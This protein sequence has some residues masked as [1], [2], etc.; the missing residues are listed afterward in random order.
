MSPDPAAIA[1]VF[2]LV[3]VMIV[4]LAL[5]RLNQS[6]PSPIFS[7]LN[8][9]LRCIALAGGGALLATRLGWSERPFA[10]LA[11]VFLLG[12]F[13][14]ETIYH[15]LAIHAMSVSPLPLF[16]RYTVNPGGDEWPVS[17]S[18]LRLRDH[19]RA[20]GF[21]FVQGLRAEV[22]TDVHLRTSFYQTS[23]ATIRLQVVFLP[24]PSGGISVCLHLSSQTADGS[25]IVTDNH[26]LPFAGFYPEAWWVERSPWTRSLGA[27]L[28]RHRQR[29]NKMGVTLVPWT[30]EPIEDVN[31]QQSRLE[32]LN[33]ELGFLLPTAEHEEHGRISSPGR[34]RIWKELF[35]LNYFG[36][37]ARYH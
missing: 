1:P 31:A 11:A 27:L 12:W 17:R 10:V 15:W 7:L 26:Y 3:P 20:A 13:L 8:R 34:Y 16:P 36:R 29:V 37:A 28:K 21:K 2:V 14:L 35:T 22:M 30:D 18:F 24:Q 32:Q 23:D 25:R 6:S 5:M 9:W 33:V 4:S 19:V